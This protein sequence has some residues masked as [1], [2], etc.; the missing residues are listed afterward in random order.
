MRHTSG[1]LVAHGTIWKENLNIIAVSTSVM[2]ICCTCDVHVLW[3]VVVVYLP[4][5]SCVCFLSWLLHHACLFLVLAIQSWHTSEIGNTQK[6]SS[7]TDQAQLRHPSGMSTYNAERTSLHCTGCLYYSI[8]QC[9]LG[10]TYKAY[11][12]HE[13]VMQFGPQNITVCCVALYEMC[14]F[15][16]EHRVGFQP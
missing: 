8:K 13:Q 7:S 15:R 9:I 3:D 11:K 6:A 10:H 4:I 12:P 1:S 2:R 14:N 5:T 16:A